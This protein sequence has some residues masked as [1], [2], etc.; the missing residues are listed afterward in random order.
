EIEKAYRSRWEKDGSNLRVKTAILWG[1]SLSNDAAQAR[2]VD[3]LTK[4]ENNAQIKQVAA[5]VKTK[6][7]GGDPFGGGPRGGGGG[8]GGM[9]GGRG[10]LLK[11]LAPLYAD[12]KIV[13]NRI[14]DFRAMRG[15]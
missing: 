3:E 12:D 9:G 6:L 10:G 1:I 5:A 15:Q 2:L 13:R 4:D 14:R 11:L 7:T 8:R